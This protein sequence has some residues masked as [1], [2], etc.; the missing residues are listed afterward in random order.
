MWIQT[1]SGE[2]F[3]YNLLSPIKMEDIAW[4]ISHTCRYNGHSRRFYSVAEHCVHVSNAVDPEYALAGL[5]HDAAEAYVG[6]LPYPLKVY[7]RS[8]GQTAFDEMEEQIHKAIF[9]MHDL[10]WPMPP[11]VKEI[12]KNML[13]VEAPALL[14]KLQPG[15]DMGDNPPPVSLRY[16]SPRMAYS[17]YMAR[18]KALTD[19]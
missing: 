17:Q 13:A 15:W 11:Q 1:Y 16:W 18:Y 5:L 8:I 6:D 9:E 10:P 14:G 4:S 19:E 3:D 2:R 7:L 12:D